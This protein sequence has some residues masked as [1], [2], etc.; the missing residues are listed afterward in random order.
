MNLFKRTVNFLLDR[1]QIFFWPLHLHKLRRNIHF[2]NYVMPK[3]IF[4]GLTIDFEQD[5]G[6]KGNGQKK[7][8]PYFKA[9][10]DEICKKRPCTLFVQG[11]LIKENATY[12]KMLQDNGH[13]LGLHG[14]RHELWGEEKWFLKDAFVQ[15]RERERLLKSALDDFKQHGLKRP[16]SFR[17]PNLIIDVATYDLLEKYD[18]RFDSSA[19]SFYGDAVVPSTHGKIFILPVT[20]H[21]KPQIRWQGPLPFFRYHA[22]NFYSLCTLNDM[23]LVDLIKTVLVFQ[24]VNHI[25]P[26]LIFF[27]HPW[28]FDPVLKATVA[29]DPISILKSKLSLIES[30]FSLNYLPIKDLGE[31][32]KSYL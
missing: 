13:E 4:F 28:E 8:I 24:Q 7:A 32:I 25:L 17:A 27:A 12:L 21:I 1:R 19:G 16:I 5:F 20:R 26:H 23:E 11:D 14:Y 29:R 31:K 9:H 3:K 2:V 30:H 6:S 22:L 10:F 18:F 15:I